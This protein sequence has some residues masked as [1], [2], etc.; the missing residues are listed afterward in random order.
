FLPN[1]DVC[2][3]SRLKRRDSKENSRWHCDRADQPRLQ[4]LIQRGRA[5]ERDVH[6][7]AARWMVSSGM[8]FFPMGIFG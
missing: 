4:H 8:F 6:G 2:P 3:E 7:S 5:R 1:R